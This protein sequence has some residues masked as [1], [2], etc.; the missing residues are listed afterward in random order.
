M[1]STVWSLEDL[2]AKK[3]NPSDPERYM[4]SLRKGHCYLLVDKTFGNRI[5][6]WRCT[7]GAKIAHFNSSFPGKGESSPH[8]LRGYLDPNEWGLYRITELQYWAIVALYK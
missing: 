6:V 3:I 1:E 4:P 5:I 7:G 8:L 2:M